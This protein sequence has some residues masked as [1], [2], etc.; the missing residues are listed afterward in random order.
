METANITL[1][2]GGS[3]DQTVRKRVT[4]AEYVLL[5]TI[6]GGEESVKEISAAKTLAQ[7]KTLTI[8]ARDPKAEEMN[9][10]TQYESDIARIHDIYLKANEEVAKVFRDL[11]PGHNPRLPT[12]FKEV[13]INLKH[14]TAVQNKID[15]TPDE[16]I[17]EV[18]DEEVAALVPDSLAGKEEV[19]PVK[20]T[21][22]KK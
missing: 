5:A 22:N 3:R 18:S 19:T 4:P 12:T 6:H 10:D 15:A 20:R 13:D 16:E 11:F 14:L 9:Y 8:S 17:D 21:G 7:G 1:L 2:L